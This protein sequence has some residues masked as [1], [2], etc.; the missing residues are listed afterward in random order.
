MKT[1]HT[2]DLL[3]EIV[4]ARC[5]L[6]WRSV[7]RFYCVCCVVFPLVRFYFLLWLSLPST[8]RRITGLQPNKIPW[9][10]EQVEAPKIRKRLG[11]VC[12]LRTKA[13][14]LPAAQQRRAS[15]YRPASLISA[16]TGALFILERQQ[17]HTTTTS[18]PAVS[19]QHFK[20]TE[21]RRHRLSHF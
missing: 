17:K 21:T 10:I 9:K 20:T 4:V 13:H 2:K 11:N 6:Q 5:F 1:T 19:Q 18:Q 16:L 8:S 3:R 12:W 15:L 7:F 14:W